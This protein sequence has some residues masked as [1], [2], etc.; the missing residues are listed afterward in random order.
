MQTG[1]PSPPFCQLLCLY[2]CC[3]NWWWMS[4]NALFAATQDPVPPGRMPQGLH[5][6]PDQSLSC[7]H[8]SS[9][10]LCGPAP[11]HL[12]FSSRSGAFLGISWQGGSA[13]LSSVCLGNSEQQKWSKYFQAS[14]SS[15]SNTPGKEKDILI[16]IIIIV[17][18]FVLSTE[19]PG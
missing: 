9:S 15:Q 18:S 3:W 2:P 6:A 1:T 13:G 7:S 4:Q 12:T 8:P 11:A 5:K 14:G 16:R 19:I 17:F 10:Q